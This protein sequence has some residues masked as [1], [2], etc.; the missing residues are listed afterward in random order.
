VNQLAVDLGA[1]RHFDQFVLHVTDNSGFWSELD[2]FSRKN[3]TVNG[4]VE[5]DMGRDD[6]SFNGT[7]LTDAQHGVLVVDCPDIALY[8]P[9][10]EET[11]AKLDV[12]IDPGVRAHQCVYRSL[13]TFSTEH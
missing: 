3:V 4:S 1:Y 9:I 8:S 12:S 2:P 13:F 7:A 5:E 11:A 6:G 10:D